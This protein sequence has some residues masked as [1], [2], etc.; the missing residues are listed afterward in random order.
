MKA[1]STHGIYDEKLA[2]QRRKERHPNPCS[3]YLL[4]DG[5]WQLNTDES[6]CRECCIA[7][8]TFQYRAWMG[9]TEDYLDGKPYLIIHV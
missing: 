3:A 1:Y 9:G 4:P 2:R 8:N 6:A 7:E 5:T